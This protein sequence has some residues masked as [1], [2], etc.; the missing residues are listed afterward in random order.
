MKK[1]TEKNPHSVLF[2]CT[3]NLCR[4]PIAA[5]YFS[6]MVKQETE[7]EW[8]IGSAGIWAKNGL[9]ALKP[10]QQIMGMHGIDIS[11]HISR[12]V[13]QDIVDSYSLILTMER[14]HKELLLSEYQYLERRLFMLTEMSGVVWTIPDPA[15]NNLRDY[16]YVAKE[17]KGWLNIGR[18]NISIL[19]VDKTTTPTE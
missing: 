9:P 17:I 11:S 16:D 6:E 12:K 19:A 8:E 4:S 10:V 13:T 2:V 7:Y 5:A 3:Y 15:G 1:Q 14:R 18:N